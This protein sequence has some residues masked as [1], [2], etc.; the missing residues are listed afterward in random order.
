MLV[1]RSRWAWWA[2]GLVLLVLAVWVIPVTM[3]AGVPSSALAAPAGDTDAGR[4]IYEARCAGCHGVEGDGNGPAAGLLDP[5]PRDFRRG[6]YKVRTTGSGELPTDE[7]L[8]HIIG[9]GMPGTAMP[10]WG[11]ILTSQEQRAVIAYIKTFSRRFGRGDPPQSLVLSKA[12]PSSPESIDRGRELYFGDLECFKCHGQEG[13]G[14]GPSALE[15]EDDYGFPIRPANLTKGWNFR[16]GH[17][18]QDIA[19]TFLTG[20]MGT[21]M[22]SYE[23]QISEKDIWHLAN[24]VHSLSPKQKPEVKAVLRARRVDGPLPTTPQ[25]PDWS[26]AEEFYYPLVGQVMKAPRNFTP[27]LD[28]VSVKALYSNEELA[29]LLIWDDRGENRSVDGDKT[30]DALSVQFPE[31]I[32][33]GSSRPF[34]VEGQPGRPVNL[35]YWRADKGAPEEMNAEGVGTARPQEPSS[36]DLTGQAVYQDGQWRL[37]V[38]RKL[39]THDSEKDIQFE[40]NRFI[41]IAFSAW[42]GQRG[43]EGTLRA[44]SAWYVLFLEGPTPA[45]DWLQIPLRV[46]IVAVLEGLVLWGARRRGSAVP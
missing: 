40:E 37:V 45:S 41:P 27:A 13:R 6:L 42:D 20:L 33:Q 25:D 10:G 7:D 1:R 14:D 12:I 44:V 17:S 28:T 2:L 8:L 35:W 11:G 46:G 32:P 15:L 5:R 19:R 36:Q 16:G 34:F 21:P 38:K 18:P 39:I 26:Q 31:Q 22:P 23:G 24:F 4:P 43:E 3:G 30:M 9:S 29:L